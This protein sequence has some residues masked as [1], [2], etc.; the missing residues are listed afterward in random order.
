MSIIT[1]SGKLYT[2][3]TDEKEGKNRIPSLPYVI[4]LSV[5]EIA[6]NLSPD[7]TRIID[8]IDP[9]YPVVFK[10]Q[11]RKAAGFI[12][13]LDHGLGLNHQEIGTFI[14]QLQRTLFVGNTLRRNPK[15]LPG[16]LQ[17]DF[18]VKNNFREPPLIHKD[19]VPKS[20]EDYYNWYE[21]WLEEVGY[22]SRKTFTTLDSTPPPCPLPRTC[23][24]YIE[25]FNLVKAHQANKLPQLTHN[26]KQVD[27]P[28]HATKQ[29]A[30]SLVLYFNRD[31]AEFSKADTILK[32]LG[33]IYRGPGQDKYVIDLDSDGI[34][35]IGSGHTSNDQGLG[36]ILDSATYSPEAF[37][38][39]YLDIC[40]G[41]GKNPAIPY[42]TS[43]VYFYSKTDLQGLEK[44]KQIEEATKKAGYPVV[45]TYLRPATSDDLRKLTKPPIT[46]K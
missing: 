39:A 1:L 37:F 16:W 15:A 2:M 17:T 7:L 44:E 21:K 32:D 42:Q 45:Y 40:Q 19:E 38:K 46:R 4:P 34:I 14:Q 8:N 3:D 12:Q 31:V 27:Y 24:A 6:R 26:L 35:K 30:W 20:D 13:L 11:A 28:I 41:A 10:E 29:D 33:I 23:K 25:S 5:G 18:L 36:G 43:F 22:P 9:R